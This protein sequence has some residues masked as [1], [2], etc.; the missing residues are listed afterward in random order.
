[1]VADI[2]HPEHTYQCPIYRSV[3]TYMYTTWRSSYYLRV[4]VSNMWVVFWQHRLRTRHGMVADIFLLW[5]SISMYYLQ[6]SVHVHV[7]NMN[8]IILFESFL[9][10]ICELYFDSP[11][12][13]QGTEW[14][15]RNPY[16]YRYWYL[17]YITVHEG[18]HN[19]SKYFL[20]N[21]QFQ[22][23]LKRDKHP[24]IGLFSMAYRLFWK[25]TVNL[26]F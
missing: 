7:H 19:I 25:Y 14:W 18:H 15:L 10:V 23:A 8:I 11:D 22:K 13:G 24:R 17:L 20:G 5:T 26:S 3:Y 2:F 9:W 6:F 4:F 16:Q 21:K 1:M 12:L